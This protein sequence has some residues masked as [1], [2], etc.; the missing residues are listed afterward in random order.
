M[1]IFWIIVCSL[2]LG[3]GFVGSILPFLPGPPLA[4]VALLIHE[5]TASDPFSTS[6]LIIW[7]S[8]TALVM[9]LEN[10]IPAIGTERFGGSKYGIGGTVVGLLIGLFIFPPIGIIAGPLLGAFVGELIG[11]Q[12]SDQAWQSALGSFIGFLAG[13]LLKVITVAMM[14]Y[15]YIQSVM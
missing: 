12:T 2:L 14:S 6:F 10:I 13:T 3:L 11:G 8:I 15:Y 7:A 9:I 1:E 4:Y 5:F